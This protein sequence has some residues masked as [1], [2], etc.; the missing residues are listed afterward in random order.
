VGRLHC[1]RGDANVD[2]GKHTNY[3]INYVLYGAAIKIG[4][5]AFTSVKHD[6]L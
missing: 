3:V 5:S 1:R 2:D 6:E 4:E